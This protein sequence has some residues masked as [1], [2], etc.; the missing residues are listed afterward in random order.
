M[1]I[2]ERFKAM[3]LRIGGIRERLGLRERTVSLFLMC[4]AHLPAAAASISLTRRQGIS[5]HLFP[6]FASPNPIR[7]SKPGAES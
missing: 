6:I 5:V 2:K 1:Q 7:W 4:R 3:K